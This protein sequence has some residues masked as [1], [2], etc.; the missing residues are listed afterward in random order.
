MLEPRLQKW[1]TTQMAT[2]DAMSLVDYVK[3]LAKYV[4]PS[5]WPHQTRQSILSARQGESKRFADWR[6]DMENK[7]EI[8][9]TLS[10]TFALSPTS[11]RDLLE[12]N[13]RTALC[14]SLAH[15]PIGQEVTYTEW[16]AEVEARDEELRDEERRLEARLTARTE[17]RPQQKK[18]LAQRLEPAA[19]TTGSSAGR[20]T[21]P[22]LT[23]AEKTLLDAHEGCR[24]CR[25]FYVGHRGDDGTCPMAKAG[26]WPDPTTYKTL[27]TTMATE[28]AADKKNTKRIPVGFVPALDNDTYAPSLDPLPPFT[29]PHLYAN[30]TALSPSTPDLHIMTKSLLDIG[31][32]STVISGRLANRLRLHRYPLPKKEDNLSSLSGT[33]LSSLEYVE[34]ELSQ[35]RGAWRSKVIRAKVNEDLPIPLILGIPFLSHEHIIIDVHAR[36]ALVRETGHDLLNPLI[37]RL[38][39]DATTSARSQPTVEFVPEN[40]ERRLYEDRISTSTTS[41][42]QTPTANPNV[43]SLSAA[44]MAAIRQRIETL[45][46][47]EQLQARDAALKH[48]FADCFPTRLPD[49]GSMPDHIY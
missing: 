22:K 42:A 19:T 40:S 43:P 47:L 44:T 31:C 32:P 16:A 3:A 45:A 1:Y 41:S 13:T 17:H 38:V 11:L 33:P 46:F 35:S 24:R 10:K 49:V 14:D 26:T 48:E 18:T 39:Y 9:D 34:L 21:L 8:L 36:T 12:A 15:R 6:V 4:L 29:M 5:N 7:N 23:D 27:T 20:I 30:F 25:K 28:A 37:P 2:I